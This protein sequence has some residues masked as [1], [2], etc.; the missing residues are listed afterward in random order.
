MTRSRWIVL[1][2]VSAACAGFAIVYSIVTGGEAASVAISVPILVIAAATLWYT[3]PQRARLCVD[4]LD[5]ADLTD[6]I[7]YIY[8]QP[9]PRGEQ[10]VP[11]DYLLQL[12]VAVSNLGG[13]KAVLSSITIEGFRTESGD[14]V[15]LPGATA[16]IGGM[17]W[18]QRTGWLNSSRVFENMNV[19][20]PYIL[21]PDDVIVLRFRTRRGIDWTSRWT[22][23]ALREFCEP[24]RSPIVSA[25][26][27]MVW[28][29]AG[30]VV[31]DHF[32][33]RMEVTQQAEYVHLVDQ[34]TQSF[35]I[36]PTVPE[37]PIALE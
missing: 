27:T 15:H 8:P 19:P 35:T 26:G 29:R 4:R 22:T 20:G 18:I 6:L 32:T 30:E 14:T 12:H 21:E 9:N 31:R 37:Q 2:V 7:F 11:R 1:A 23:D 36:L 13:R 28:R 16:T 25:S 10:Q 24:L 5:E 17:Q 33:V 34:L 3:V